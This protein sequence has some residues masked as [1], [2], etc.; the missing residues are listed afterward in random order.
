MTGSSTFTL[1]LVQM[2]VTGDRP[3]TLAAAT[4]K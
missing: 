1:G 2:A 4:E 3:A